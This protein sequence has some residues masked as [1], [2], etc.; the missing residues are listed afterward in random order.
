MKKLTLLV[1]E[2][3]RDAFVLKLREAGALHVKHVKS[4]DTHEVRFI[5]ERAVK[6][7]K[8]IQALSSYSGSGAVSQEAR[9]EEERQ[10]FSIAL[11]VENSL[12]EKKEN[13]LKIKKINEKQEW[14]KMWGEINPKDISA[15]KEQGVNLRIYK[16]PKTL[17]SVIPAR[18]VIYKFTIKKDKNYTYEAVVTFKNDETLPFDEIKMPDESKDDL[19]KQLAKRKERENG[20]DVFLKETAARTL[21]TARREKEKLKKEQEFLKVR[22]GMSE[23]GKFS[24]LQGFCP[25]NKINK[26]VSMAREFGVGYLI[27]EPDDPDDTPTLITNPKWLKMIAPVF[28]FMNTLPGYGEFDIS[29]Y[30]LLFFSLFFAM[31]IGD[32]GY[33]LLFLGTTF[34]ARKKFKN[35]PK[36][37]FLLMYVLSG[38]TIVWGILTGTWFGAENIPYKPFLSTGDENQKMLIYICFAI[39]AVHLTI[40]HLLKAVRMINS[41]KALAEAG[42]IMILWVMFFAAGKFVIGNPFPDAGVWLLGLGFILV[43]LFTKPEKGIMKGAIAMMTELPL[44]IISS[45]SD[46]VS[47]LRLFA[48][49]YATVIVARSFNSM[50]FPAEAG[51]SAG[52]SLKNGIL[53]AFGSAAILFFG[54]AL[55]IVLGFMAVIVHGI[56]LNML[57]FSSHLGMQWSGKKYEPFCEGERGK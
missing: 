29:F 5:E 4:C 24:Y 46:I 1:S 27:E 17:S 51:V 6:L 15:L 3:Q 36:E 55:N 14:F 35:L 56:R 32:A 28:Q 53:G 12:Q 26:I 8:M 45:F 11:E 2:K 18:A 34:W 21:N 50:A 52:F 48:V 43:L 13:R 54:H 7:E 20:I 10:I 57:E 47:Y 9:P 40:A 22:C 25:R 19:T 49:G 39:G 42:W 31:L 44:S 30:F 37:P 38:A 16:I 33:G 23:E 41:A